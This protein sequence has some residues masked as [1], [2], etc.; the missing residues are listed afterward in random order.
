MIVH[1]YAQGPG[2]ET[3][4][5]LL[6]STSALAA[7][8]ARVKALLSQY[9]G[10]NAAHVQ[11]FV[12]ET[13]SV[14][15]NPGK[16]TVSLVNGLFAADD[17]MDWLENGVANVDW[18]DLHNGS[19]SGDNNSGGLYG[20]ANY[21]DYGL[22]SN[23]T[24]G[25]PA[26]D[27]PFAPY[28]GIQMVSKLG[29]PG[30]Q[31]VSASSS[32]GLLA[33]HAVK[34]AGGKLALLLINKDPSNSVAASISVSGFTP[35]SA[36]TV[37][38][39]G[40]SS[41]AITSAAGSAGSSFTQTVPPYSLTTV[42]LAPSG[43]GGGTPPPPPPPAPSAPVWSVTATASPATVAPGAA[44]QISAVVKDSGGAYANAVVDLEVYNSSGAKV[45]QQYFSGQNFSA[46]A[47]QTYAWRWTAPPATGAYHVAAGVFSANWSS[48]LYWNPSA[49]PITVAAPVQADA[50]PYNFESGTQGWASSGGMISGV[51]SATTQAFAGTHSL[52]VQFS[53]SHADAQQ[54]F[55]GAPATPAGKTVTFHVWIPAGSAVTAVQPF[56]QQ[57]SGGGWSWTGNYQAASS[58]KAGP[59]NTLTV[60]VPANAVTPLYQLGVQ[61]FTGGAW[62]GTCYVDSVSW[63]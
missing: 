15:Y 47:S 39:F 5:G 16:Q 27:T 30:D 37:F 3:D 14:P 46:G 18:W 56:V 50:A 12:T 6:S 62:S 42:V 57:G 43:S 59:W 51:S 35:A 26:A 21:G 60:A 55:V 36:S 53:G 63:Q 13:N 40:Q 48:N 61:F 10:A 34:Q 28:Y 33:V 17:Y 19:L 24:A 44:S 52:A 7:K 11:I 41:S 32:Q 45:G 31:M 58:L 8:V 29:K 20:S 49:A 1:W 2:S 54:V 22:L 25:E 9:C 38:S 23:A 4:S